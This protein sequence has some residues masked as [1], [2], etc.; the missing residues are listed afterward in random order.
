MAA[1]YNKL[2]KRIADLKEEGELEQDKYAAYQRRFADA[3]CDDLNS[4][5]AI[6]ALYDM[7]KAD[8]TD[9]TKLALAKSFEEVLSLGLFDSKE[10]EADPELERYVLERIEARKAAK[11]AK[12]FATADA[13]R[14]ELLSKG[15]I[16][17]DTR[18]GVRWKKA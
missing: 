17:E 11:K 1:A 18:E 5:M 14:E 2:V 10:E 3:L 16:L 6:T 12:D 15:I 4:A 8:M 13:I 9:C 7:L